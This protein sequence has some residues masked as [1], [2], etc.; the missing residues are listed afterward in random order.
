[1]DDKKVF[2]LNSAL[3]FPQACLVSMKWGFSTERRTEPVSGLLHCFS[4]HAVFDQLYFTL[5][6]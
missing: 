6:Q 1:M 3:G 4:E 5:K 2:N